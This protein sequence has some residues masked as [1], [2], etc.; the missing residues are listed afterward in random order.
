MNNL[1]YYILMLYRICFKW[2]QQAEGPCCG[3]QR[4]FNL[5]ENKS[6]SH[7]GHKM[8]ALKKLFI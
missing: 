4:G 3:N 6:E 5:R 1:I 8:Q 2:I 7:C